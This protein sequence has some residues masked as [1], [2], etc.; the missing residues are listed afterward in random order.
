MADTINLR[1]ARK[2]KVREDEA[3]RAEANR[4]KFGASKAEKLQTKAE[5]IRTAKAFDGH[6][7]E[8]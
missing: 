1:T 4:V 5:A 2:R 7:I 3:K 6:K 8:H